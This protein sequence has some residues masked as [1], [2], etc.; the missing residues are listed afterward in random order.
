MCF[1]GSSAKFFV[2]LSTIN[3]NIKSWRFIEFV[4]LLDIIRYQFISDCDI[5]TIITPKYFMI[6]VYSKLISDWADNRFI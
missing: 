6:S 3:Q 1:Y 5:F 4:W 2:D